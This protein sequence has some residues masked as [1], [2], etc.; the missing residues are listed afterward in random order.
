MSQEQLRLYLSSALGELDRI[1][2]DLRKQTPLTRESEIY[3]LLRELV[4]EQI[5]LDDREN[6]RNTDHAAG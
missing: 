5:G 4:I 3:F 1:T 2:T 6:T